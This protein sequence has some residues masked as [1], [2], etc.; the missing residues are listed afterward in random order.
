[1]GGFVSEY[2]PPSRE[3]RGWTRRPAPECAWLTSARLRPGREVRL[4]DASPGGVLFD[5]ALRLLP[6]A[7]VELQASI[8]GASRLLVGRVVRCRV[9]MVTPRLLYRAAIAFD[10]PVDVE[11]D[12]DPGGEY[13]LPSDIRA[14]G[15]APGIGY[16]SR[17][18]SP[19]P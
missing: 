19:G 9:S 13:Q 12:G 17:V 1:V 2:W 14:D 11:S 3:R 4:I 10:D 5:T 15:G 6:A 16:P 8:R 7:R 18:R